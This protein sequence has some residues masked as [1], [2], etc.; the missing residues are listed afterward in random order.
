MRYYT[1]AAEQLRTANDFLWLGGKSAAH[2]LDGLSSL[3]FPA[4]SCLPDA[5]CS[6]ARAAAILS[7][8]LEG[9][10]TDGTTLSG[11]T[12]SEEPDAEI[13]SCLQESLSCFD[14]VSFSRSS[15]AGLCNSWSRRSWM[16]PS[17]AESCAC[18][19]SHPRCVY[20]ASSAIS[21]RSKLG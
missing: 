9:A 14:K 16:E 5:A 6:E 17:V 8:Q 12:M 21:R 3:T 18:G 19:F 13:V 20:S 10:V 15:A 11:E 2:G 7:S 4:V 1:S